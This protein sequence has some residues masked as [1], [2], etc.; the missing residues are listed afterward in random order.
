VFVERPVSAVLL[1]I[2]VAILLLPRLF[3]WRRRGRNASAGRA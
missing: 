2:V 3:A 1:A